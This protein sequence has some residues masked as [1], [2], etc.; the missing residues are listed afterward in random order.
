[1]RIYAV[2]PWERK[3]THFI[4][5]LF[6]YSIIHSQQQCSVLCR[7]FDF[8]WRPPTN[9]ARNSWRVKI[10]HVN[11]NNCGCSTNVH[12]IIHTYYLQTYVDH[13]KSLSWNSQLPWI[14]TKLPV[15]VHPFKRKFFDVHP[16]KI[17]RPQYNLNMNMGKRWMITTKVI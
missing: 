16:H 10:N 15:P 1:M 9:G 3:Q 14:H 6:E 2:I 11:Q 7:W 4:V 17:I 13:P 12:Y 5:Y 8:S